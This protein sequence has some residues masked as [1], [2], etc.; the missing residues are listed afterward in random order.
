MI[1]LIVTSGLATSQQRPKYE[2][3]PDHTVLLAIASQAN[4]PLKIE[5]ATFLKRVDQPEVLIKYRVRN[6]SNKPISFISVM[7]QNSSGSNE[8][9]MPLGRSG[10]LL[11]NETLD[12]ARLGIDYDIVGVYKSGQK[13][14]ASGG[15]KTL[16]I[17]LVEKVQFTDGSTYED[18]RT[19]DALFRFFQDGCNR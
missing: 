5:D 16:Y 2:T 10:R 8:N 14:E 1:I 6:V 18:N 13:Q 17:L 4:C 11:P 7:I 15:L 9:F 12:S 19:L 3:V